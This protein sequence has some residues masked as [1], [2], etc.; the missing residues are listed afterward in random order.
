MTIATYS[1]FGSVDLDFC[2]HGIL[3]EHIKTSLRNR[4]GGFDR[5]VNDEQGLRVS[6]TLAVLLLCRNEWE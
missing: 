6:A 5:Q 4:L 3:Q 1:A 2:H